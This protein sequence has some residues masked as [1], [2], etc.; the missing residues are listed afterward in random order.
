MSMPH[1]VVHNGFAMR[2][3]EQWKADPQAREQLR[4][5]G[6]FASGVLAMCDNAEFR[7]VVDAVA[8]LMH[9]PI[10][11]ISILDRDRQWFPCA[12]GLDVTETSRDF[13]LCSDVDAPSKAGLHV[14]DIT[15]DTRHSRNPLASCAPFIRSYFAL[16]IETLDGVALG[17]LCAMYLTPQTMP[18][19]ER[20]LEMAIFAQRVADEIGRP[21]NF[22][23]Y[24]A[25]AIEQIV[26]QIRSAAQ[27]DDE[28]LLLELDRV[29]R[30]VEQRMGS[31]RSWGN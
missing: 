30:R 26:D 24:G 5:A 28:P 15:L 7:T 31:R 12:R 20:R 8:L 23:R 25:Q 10:S 29:L 22:R 4:Q 16:P 3:T 11:A 17:A 13:A 21:A 27:C 9:A 14:S 6:V 19:L 18:S 1:K 2:I